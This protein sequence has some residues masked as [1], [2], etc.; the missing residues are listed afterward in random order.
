MSPV[1]T[2]PMSRV[3]SPG[4]EELKTSPPVRLES[5]LGGWLV[6]GTLFARMSLNIGESLRIYPPSDVYFAYGSIASIFLL[7]APVMLSKIN[8]PNYIIGSLQDLFPSIFNL[9]DSVIRKHFTF[10]LNNWNRHRYYTTLTNSFYHKDLSH[11]AS[12]CMCLFQVGPELI[13]EFGY[14]TFATVFVGGSIAGNIGYVHLFHIMRDRYMSKIA[15]VEQEDLG[16]IRDKKLAT[17]KAKAA[18][19]DF[20]LLYMQ[21]YSG[22]VGASD[23]VIAVG[24]FYMCR[25]LKKLLTAKNKY[26]S[27]NDKKRAKL[28]MGLTMETL[29]YVVQPLAYF[30]TE[31]KNIKTDV[32]QKGESC[33][34]AHV[35]GFLFGMT[36]F[37]L[38]ETWSAAQRWWWTDANDPLN[39][40]RHN[41]DIVG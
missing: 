35:Y 28:F 40:A 41:K 5:P 2:R 6:N 20:K 15:A 25:T 37:G 26:R 33:H 24:S 29:W 17:R 21:N 4:F 1:S 9:S 36:V 34:V 23:G 12:N 38:L 7:S 16:M 8:R 27:Y 13:L 3:Y 32:T 30:F 19:F 31:V 39:K 18:S 11:L 10:S 14:L 22:A